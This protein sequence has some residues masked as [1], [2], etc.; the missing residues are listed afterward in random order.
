[1]GLD[2]GE[3]GLGGREE[4]L[5]PHLS[6]ITLYVASPWSETQLVHKTVACGPGSGQILPRAGKGAGK[7]V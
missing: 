2:G 5:Y 7:E 6:C 1:M 4:G 3:D